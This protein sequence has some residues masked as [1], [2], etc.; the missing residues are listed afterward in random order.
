[1]N[2]QMWEAGN[3]GDELFDNG[4]TRIPWAY[5]VPIRRE[6]DADFWI[7]LLILGYF[8]LLHMCLSNGEDEGCYD[9]RCSG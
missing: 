8:T 2:E 4:S 9:L 3:A 7:R 5:R 1:M 6:S